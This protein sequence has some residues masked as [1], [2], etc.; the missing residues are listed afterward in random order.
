MA[1]ETKGMGE[2]RR[3]GFKASEDRR[4]FQARCPRRFVLLKPPA[5]SQPAVRVEG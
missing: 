4:C 5:G 2:S 3:R 1:V